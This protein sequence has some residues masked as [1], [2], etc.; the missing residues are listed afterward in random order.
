MIASGSEQQMMVRPSIEIQAPRIGYG[1]DIVLRDI[2]LSLSGP[3]IVALVGR[4]GS[5]KSTLLKTAA[6]LLRNTDIRVSIN[7]HPIRGLSPRE[8]AALVAWVPQRAESVFAMSLHE[9]VRVGR[10][11]MTTP[12]RV[13][14]GE[15]DAIRAAVDRVGLAS[16]AARDVDTL[17]GGEWQRALVA[18][19]VLQET[20]VLLL[21]EPVASLDLQYQDEVYRLLSDLAR[22]GRLVLVADHHL[23]VAASYADRILGIRDGRIVADGTPE[24]VLTTEQIQQ[25]FG[26]R[27]QV[28]PDPVT[29]TPRL[30]RPEAPR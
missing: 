17:S 30:S 4:N 25:I 3:G 14:P 13:A 22:G 11:R 21:D 10:Y 26:V 19:A 5:G 8:V 29:G 1:S 12:L 7:G 28:F 24:Q 18:R 2:S 15:E 6:G 20:P 27:V 23:E 9:M 16:L